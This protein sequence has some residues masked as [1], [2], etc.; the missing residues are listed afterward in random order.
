M[1]RHIALMTSNPKKLAEYKNRFDLY[2]ID[3]IQKSKDLDAEGYLKDHPK[4]VAVL[5]EESNLYRDGET[6]DRPFK[7]LTTAVNN[8]RMVAWTLEE[9][10]LEKT[11][12]VSEIEGYIDTSRASQNDEEVFDWDDI[13][14]SL[15]T[16]R[17]YHE[18]RCLGL[19]LSA[20]DRVISKFVRNKI[21]YDEH[22]NL[23]WN[24]QNMKGSVDFGHDP[25]KFIEEHPYYSKLEGKLEKILKNALADGLFLRA[26][27]NRRE[28][29]YWLPGLNAGVPLTPKRDDFHEATFMMHDFG[30]FAFPDLIFDGEASEEHRR[31]YI[32]YRMMSEAFTLVLGDMVFVDFWK[33][34]GLD[35]DFAKRRIHPLYAN[36]D[37]KELERVL[38]A[39]ARYCLLGDTKAYAELGVPDEVFEHFRD[40]YEQFFVS[41]YHWTA[42]NF[43]Y[44]SENAAFI[45]KWMSDIKPLREN[46]DI[47]FTTVS[48]FKNRLADEGVNLSKTDEVFEAVF[49]HYLNRLD[50]L[51]SREAPSN[52]S[53]K[54]R[55]R[56][57]TRY[58]L[59]QLAIFSRY[60]FV[61]ES[62]IYKEKIVGLLAQL[63]FDIDDIRRVRDFYG[64][65]LHILETRGFISKSDELTYAEVFP[66]FDP[67]YVGYD[68]KTGETVSE[69]MESILESDN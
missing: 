44:M 10:E 38:Y 33:E 9:S 7:D 5:R 8:T 65:Y 66:L 12:Y 46:L 48:E 23:R 54:C 61:D 58:L 11:V 36:M 42:R 20:R 47:H 15:G 37:D 24:P 35:Y 64:Q 3:V 60:D 41:D 45:K 16:H 43:D 26:A 17:T 13:F 53:E 6:L 62:E 67:F 25:V 22:I 19:K 63:E 1:A 27:K 50:M 59:G 4:A 32:I 49:E 18:M 28:K 57:F 29:I 31:I 55:T 51:T 40:K 30:H 69:A 2:G 68:T 56:G 52:L 21:W 34:E 39:N 14:V